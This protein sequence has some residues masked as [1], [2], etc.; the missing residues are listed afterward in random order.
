MKSLLMWLLI[1][2]F[3][4]NPTLGVASQDNWPDYPI[5]R[6]KLKGY[7]ETFEFAIQ[8]LGVSRSVSMTDI[9]D[10]PK[11]VLHDIRVWIWKSPNRS[12]DL[13]NVSLYS[14]SY[15]IVRVCAD[16]MVEG[17]LLDINDKYSTLIYP[18]A[19]YTDGRL[20]F[21]RFD[22]PQ[23]AVEIYIHNCKEL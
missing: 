8:I 11:A 21:E 2:L 18:Q 16:P 1:V 19:H 17:L 13:H 23:G 5:D 10:N 20:A 7:G 15:G 3:L 12:W 4:L 6:L 9:L 14:S 22:I